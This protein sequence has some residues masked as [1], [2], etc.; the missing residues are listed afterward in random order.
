MKGKLVTCLVPAQYVFFWG[1]KKKTE[2]W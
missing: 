2:D 1:R